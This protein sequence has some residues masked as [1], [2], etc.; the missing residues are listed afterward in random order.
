MARRNCRSS[1]S[2]TSGTRPTIPSACFSA[3]VKAVDLF[4]DGSWST[5]IPRLFVAII[6]SFV[7]VVF[8]SVLYRS[9]GSDSLL[10]GFCNIGMDHLRGINDAVELVLRHKSQLQ[11]GLLERGVVVQCIVCNLRRLVIA[12]DGGKGSH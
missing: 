3:S 10:A 1:V 2:V 12:N 7:F 9:A 11:C 6:I 8:Y 4:S 5:S